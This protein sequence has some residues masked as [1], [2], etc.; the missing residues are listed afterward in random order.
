M[1]LPIAA[2]LLALSMPLAAQTVTGTWSGTYSFSVQLSACSNQTF[3]SS[4]NITVVFLQTGTALVGRA[5]LT[6]DLAFGGTCS[7]KNVEATHEIIGAVGPGTINWHYPNDTNG[8]TFT[9]T[10]SGDKI[11]GSITDVNG[12]T[13]TVSLTR[14]AAT[15]D[16]FLTGNWG[17]TYTFKDICSNGGT[18]SYNGNF[19][20]ALVQVG[21]YATGVVTMT[22][23]PLYDQNCANIATLTQTMVVA[24]TVS[25]STFSGAVFDPSGSFDFPF[26]AT[27][28]NS[29]ISGTVQGASATSTTGTFTLTQSAQQAPA[30]DFQGAYNGTY[31]ETD[32]YTS[33]CANIGGLSYGGAA[34]LTLVQ[35]GDMIAGALIFQDVQSLSIVDVFSDCVQVPV[36]EEVLPIY[37]TIVNGV[38]TLDLPLGGGATET[39]TTNLTATSANGTITDSFGDQAAFTTTKSVTPTPSGPRRRAVN[40]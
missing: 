21:S 6:N 10:I 20:M 3:S 26:T 4:G 24:G 5:D 18:I 8:T 29:G 33:V 7:P 23:V 17:G 35:A 30:V 28:G 38:L 9:G 37:G 13:G 1:R 14:T 22:N 16:V 15:P 12:A 32:D 25:G 27:I 19:T 36:G 40:P 11:S 2:A 34:S 39:V 31:N